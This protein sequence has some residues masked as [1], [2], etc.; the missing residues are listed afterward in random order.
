MGDSRAI[1]IALFSFYNNQLISFKEMVRAINLYEKS[2]GTISPG[3][4]DKQ[5]DNLR[6]TTY[7]G[8][9]LVGYFRYPKQP[10]GSVRSMHIVMWV[11]LAVHT[12]TADEPGKEE[13]HGKKYPMVMSSAKRC[14]LLKPHFQ[15]E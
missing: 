3:S 2:S 8:A 14:V 9:V 13:N 4:I 11:E 6:P 12:L 10:M 5:T 7:A 1:K 15:E